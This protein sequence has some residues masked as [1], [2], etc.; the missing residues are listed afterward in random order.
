VK[1]IPVLQEVVEGTWRKEGELKALKVDLTALERQIQLSLK[2]IEQS[3]GESDDEPEKEVS[4]VATKSEDVK[5][6]FLSPAGEERYIAGEKIQALFAG[7][8]SP[9]DMV[10]SSD[11]RVLVCSPS[12][13]ETKDNPMKGIRI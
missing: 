4:P 3:E 2:P 12:H 7:K 13:G 11:N 5:P 1:D 6:K 9:K 10:Q 8:L